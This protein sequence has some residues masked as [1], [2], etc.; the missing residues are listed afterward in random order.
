[1]RG[2]RLDQATTLMMKLMDSNDEYV[3]GTLTFLFCFMLSVLIESL[4]S[5]KKPVHALP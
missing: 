3:E 2:R 4:E 1:M 5:R